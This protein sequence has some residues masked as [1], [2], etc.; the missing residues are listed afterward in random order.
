[1]RNYPLICW[2]LDSR[3]VKDVTYYLVI[4]NNDFKAYEKVV[5]GAN[6]TNKKNRLLSINNYHYRRGGA[7]ALYLD[8]DALFEAA[9]WETAQFSM[10]HPENNPSQFSEFFVDEIEYGRES[11][12]T[13]KL[14]MASK[15]IYSFEAKTQL[16]RLLE[17]FYPDI[18]HAH[19]IYHHLSPSI[20]PLLKQRG[21]PV[22]LTAHDFKLICPAYKMLN[23]G[24]ICERC[25]DGTTWNVTWHRCVKDS[26]SLSLLIGIETYIHRMMDIYA[27]NL[28]KLVVPSRFYAR[29]FVDWGWSEEKIKYVPNFV[30]IDNFT[31]SYE[32]GDYVVYIGRLIGDKGVGTLIQAAAIAKVKVV[33]VGTGNE[34]EKFQRMALDLAA[35]VEFVGYKSGD[36]LIELVQQSRAVVLPSEIYENAPISVLEAY[37]CGKTVIGADIGGI[38]ELIEEEATGWLFPSKSVEVLA[39]KLK[40]VKDLPDKTLSSMGEHARTFVEQKFTKEKYLVSMQEL[41][42]ELGVK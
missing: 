5:T 10:R 35:P 36:A 42:A 21:I 22:V 2:R 25:R 40:I 23:K 31:P 11:G 41:Y 3:P 9:G 20:L 34:E 13:K 32:P 28:D 37:S 4:Y 8:H 39:D 33:I 18:V 24:Q 6:L 30:E 15:I 16:E 26:F 1:L 14:T 19:N 17:K 7:D 38:P 12:F 29:K 27:K